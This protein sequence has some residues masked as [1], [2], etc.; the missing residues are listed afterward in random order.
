MELMLIQPILATLRKHRVTVI[1]LIVQVAVTCAIVTNV[2]FLVV[3]RVDRIDVASGVDETRVSMLNSVSVDA[4]EN[5]LARHASDLD[6]LRTIP[7]VTAV[8]A[9]DSL[10]LGKEESSYGACGSMDAFGKAAKANTIDVPGCV[11]PA[12]MA[13]T[14]G[15]LKVL[16]LHLVEGRSFLPQDYVDKGTPPVTII[17]QTL[18]QKLYPGKEPLG[19][20]VVTG[21]QKPIRVIGVVAPI[22]RPRLNT[23]GTNQQV[24]LWPVLPAEARITYILRS[25]PADRQRVLKQAVTALMKLD[26]QR[27]IN[28]DLMR[29]YTQLRT[30]YFQRDTTMISL[31]V[32]SVLGLVFVT[33]LGIA[34]LASFWVQQRRKSIGIRR[35]I[36]ATRGDILR[37]FQ[38]ENFII[39]S[40]G[41]VL[42][43]LL[44]LGLNLLLMRQYE[45][46][47]L[48]LFY[49]PVG[50]VAM[51]LLGQL[52]VL[53]PALR[54]SA[55]SPVVATKSF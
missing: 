12:V 17:S 39:V 26:S 51:W 42:G 22:L 48:P 35:A 1:L 37:Y 5:S 25:A 15:E 11:Q 7:G 33:A 54:A 47:R 24:M 10:P 9:V 23:L 30:E 18:A 28:P 36:G 46:T 34:G 43:A 20:V 4:H 52:A 8:A 53:N 49:L 55:V 32:S 44:A 14:E 3:Q 13:G 16:G 27:I 45:L 40:A 21:S 29:T 31:L 50:A 38:T 6:V 2:I 41:V 19:Q